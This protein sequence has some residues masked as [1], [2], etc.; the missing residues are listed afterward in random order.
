MSKSSKEAIEENGGESTKNYIFG[1][2]FAYD[3]LDA[4][5][6]VEEQH[7]LN[8]M[9]LEKNDAKLASIQRCLLQY[10]ERHG[11]TLCEYLTIKSID[12]F[13]SRR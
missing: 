2:D 7:E 12:R 11:L 6:M 5:D 10:V 4:N 8:E 1:N 9:A 13:L 3:V